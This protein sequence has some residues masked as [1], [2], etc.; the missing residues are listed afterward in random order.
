MKHRDRVKVE[1]VGAGT[2][3]KAVKFN[4]LDQ[5]NEESFVIIELDKGFWSESKRNY[6]TIIVAH[7]DNCKVVK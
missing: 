5:P 4:K 6:I 2:V 3:L 1:D 7:I